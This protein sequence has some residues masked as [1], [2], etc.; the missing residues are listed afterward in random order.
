[1]IWRTLN[2]SSLR[3]PEDV[4]RDKCVALR[5]ESSLIDFTE[6]FWSVIEP[7]A[8]QRSWHI[9]AICDHLE[10]VANR[11]IKQGLLMNIPP[12]HMK[13]LGAN[14]FFPAWIWAQD[15]NPDNDPKYRHQL[16]K[17]SWR[18]PGVK[19]MHLSYEGRLATRDGGKCRRIIQSPTYQ[20]LWARRYQMM[21]DQTRKPDLITQPAVT[22]SRHRKTALLPAKGATSSSSTI[23][24][25]QEN[26]RRQ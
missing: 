7:Q 13:S 24:Q 19:F 22:V 23:P 9:E 11:E 10:A 20:Q 25:R 4:L 5:F 1:M 17:G 18:G 26:G 3:S 6:A 16:R 14:V 12:R 2:K 8:F 15:P 21:T